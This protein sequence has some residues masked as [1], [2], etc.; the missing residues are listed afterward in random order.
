MPLFRRWYVQ[1]LSRR[2]GLMLFLTIA[3]AAVL[4]FRDARAQAVY[5]CTHEGKVT[6]ADVPCAGGRALPP[7]RTPTPSDVAA[8]ELQA[9]R[10]KAV[11][12]QREADHRTTANGSRT[13]QPSKDDAACL[14]SARQLQRAQE[15]S[16][17]GAGRAVKRPHR[18]AP[19][20]QATSRPP[21]QEAAYR[22]E[23]RRR[24]VERLRAAVE[25]RCTQ[26]AG[27]SVVSGAPA[28]ATH[29]DG[30]STATTATARSRP[31]RRS[32]TFAAN[33]E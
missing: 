3:V 10:D 6:Y 11:L 5:R 15:R 9:F 1:L 33:G 2:A 22:A 29:S 12:E 14:A 30:R 27:M 26:P 31:V 28:T 17:E 25:R 32:R 13:K 21:R 18:Q 23:A 8:A 19:S 20:R 7:P 4:P 24:D 16:H